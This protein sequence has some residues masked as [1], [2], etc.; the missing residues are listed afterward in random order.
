MKPKEIILYGLLFISI[1]LVIWI[2]F[3]ENYYIQ[4][5]LNIDFLKLNR[6]IETFAIAYVS[7][8]IF[9]YVVVVLKEKADRKLILPFVADYVYIAMNN[10][11]IFCSTMR[12]T[13]GLE[14]IPNETSIHNRNLKI[15]PN[16]EELK[17]ICSTI[18]P[19]QNINGDIKID[20]LIIIP[21]FF[22]IMIN[23]TYR[24]DYFVKMVLEKSSFI[25]VELLRILTDIQTHGYH[26]HLLSYDKKSLL[27]AKHRN[28]NLEVFNKSLKSYLDL[29]IKL[30]IY[31][32]RNLKNH[33][34]R[35]SLK[36][37]ITPP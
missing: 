15:Y 28:E 8:F 10:C 1:L 31:A 29:F 19:N 30:E 9:Y 34:E 18:N 17:T 20:G 12:S 2:N 23:Y 24:I 14:H 25:D 27:T 7:S 22:G 11:M 3:F 26:Q 21:H 36:K 13:A 32:E 33:V 37:K 5:N 35:I 4:T 16:E 6:I